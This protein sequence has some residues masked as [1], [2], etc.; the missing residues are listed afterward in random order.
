MT[1]HSSNFGQVDKQDIDDVL[2]AGMRSGGVRR[3]LLLAAGCSSML[4]YTFADPV[5]AQA[6]TVN[7][8]QPAEP[9]PDAFM[10]RAFEMR[11]LAVKNGDRPYGAVIVRGGLI[12]GQSGSLVV[13]DSDPTAHAEL[14]TIRQTS[15][16]LKDRNLAGATMY[17]SSRPCPMCEAAAY[18]AGIDRMVFGRGL[19][20]AGSPGLCG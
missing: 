16:R 5:P 15:R 20:D 7:I 9:S 12:I 6:A 14:A 4:F 13:L 1:S 11:D 17:S 19:T 8:D 3:R 18:W 2:G 10:L